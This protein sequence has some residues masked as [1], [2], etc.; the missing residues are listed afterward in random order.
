MSLIITEKTL[1]ER[2]NFLEQLLNLVARTPKLCSSTSVLTFLEASKISIK[3]NQLQKPEP[4]KP[5]VRK[6]EK[7]FKKNAKWE[8][9]Y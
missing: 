7:F 9:V 5:E 6:N 3:Q 4:E 1:N 2:K 8:G